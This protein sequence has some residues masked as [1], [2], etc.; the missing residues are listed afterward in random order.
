MRAV[1]LV[2]LGSLG[3]AME[4]TVER[5]N[6]TDTFQQEPSAEVDILWV[7]DN[8]PSM[9]EEQVLLLTEACRAL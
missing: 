1:S 7:V 9:A 3:C 6:H 2:L 5:R 4:N 8:S